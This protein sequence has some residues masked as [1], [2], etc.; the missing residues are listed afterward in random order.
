MGKRRTQVRQVRKQTRQVKPKLAPQPEPGTPQAK[1][2]REKYVASGGFLQGYAPEFVLRVG[3][4]AIGVAV[5]CLLVA[6]VIVLFFPYGLPVHIAAALAWVIPIAFLLSFV[7][8]GI[9]LAR[10]DAKQE[11]RL[12]QGQ[13]LGA[14]NVSTSLGLGMIMVKT[15]AGQEQYLCPPDKLAR[16]PGN[17]VN[18]ALSVTP[19]LR[20]V[21]SVSIMGQRMVGRPDQPVPEVLKRLR[22]LPL[23]TPVALA[24]A[25]IVGD[26]ATALA[27][28]PNDL[29]HT[30]LALVV[31]ALLGGAVYGLSLLLQRRLMA[32]V[33][34]LVPGGLG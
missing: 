7:A 14:S 21:R 13:L 3:Y 12:V 8:P 9:R 15:R 30:L 25:V 32:A 23:V 34:A 31:G 2:Q 29:V 6:I 18:V 10:R 28:I 26:D 11:A 24:L 19:N 27:P 22:L 33:Q 20:H 5:A 16:V 1:R 4:I 17:V